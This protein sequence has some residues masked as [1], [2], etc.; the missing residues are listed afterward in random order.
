MNFYEN[1]KTIEAKK[2][3]EKI[4]KIIVCYTLIINIL[5]GFMDVSTIS[6]ESNNPKA[7]YKSEYTV[8]FWK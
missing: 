1:Y 8:C 2:I 3:L 7:F 6:M 5:T 4:F